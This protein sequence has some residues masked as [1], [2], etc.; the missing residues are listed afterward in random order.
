[1]TE[2][3]RRVGLG[4]NPSWY[5]AWTSSGRNDAGRIL[6]FVANQPN[7]P[8]GNGPWDVANATGKAV[9][10]NGGSW[11]NGIDLAMA[12]PGGGQADVLLTNPGNY[13]SAGSSVPLGAL[14]PGDDVMAAA[15]AKWIDLS[16]AAA[17]LPFSQAV[18]VMGGQTAQQAAQIQA[19]NGS[20]VPTSS[21]VPVASSTLSL[22]SI[23]MWAWLV[24]AGVVAFFVFGGSDNG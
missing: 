23:P 11:R 15:I 4:D 24:A 3:R 14:H 18:S 13:T 9:P 12:Y 19:I 7:Q 5:A 8:D 2:R 22:A 17:P 1:M 20:P 21:S 6:Q 10:Y 16:A